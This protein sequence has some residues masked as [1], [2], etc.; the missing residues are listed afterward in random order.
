MQPC[1]SYFTAVSKL[2]SGLLGAWHRNRCTH[3]M[4]TFA[5]HSFVQLRCF[6]CMSTQP[7]SSTHLTLPLSKPQEAA[8]HRKCSCS[9]RLMPTYT[10]SRGA[11][12]M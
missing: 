12:S 5:L 4:S 9:S 3:G 8:K 6:R 1:S 10:P 11:I 7:A 2:I